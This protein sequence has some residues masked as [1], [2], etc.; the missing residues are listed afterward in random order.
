MIYVRSG[1]AS[2]PRARSRWNDGRVSDIQPT[3]AVFRLPW[4]AIV[5]PFL[6]FAAATPLATWRP[7]L[8]WVY[9]VPIGSLVWI[10][11]TRTV[12]TREAISTQ[13][14][15]GR[16]R[17]DWDDFDRFEFRQSR[18]AIAVT[19]AGERI[20]LPMVRPR[21][22]PRLTAAAGGGLHLAV[23]QRPAEEPTGPAEETGPAEDL[24]D[25]PAT[26]TEPTGD[27]R[28]DANPGDRE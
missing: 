25:E 15:A 16:R 8:L 24:L 20:R 2:T 12:V 13:G 23:P 22:L 6:L 4:E 19:T 14:L 9:L 17:I 5:F 26:P 3:R 1:F 7:W 10:L 27:G 21:D 18:W 28:T 11:I